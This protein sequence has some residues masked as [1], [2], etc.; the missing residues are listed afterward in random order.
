MTVSTIYEPVVYEGNGS[1]TSFP[2]TFNYLGVVNNVK[3]SIRN[4]E[5]G[6]LTV[7][8]YS[9]HYTI[10]GSN[11]V[12]NSGNKPQTGENVIIELYINLLQE[13]DY[14]ENGRLSAETLERDLD[15]L[16]LGTQ[17]LADSVDRTL[18]VG[19][20][21]DIDTLTPAEIIQ[22]VFDIGTPGASGQVL[23]TNTDGDLVWV[24][25]GESQWSG[26][27]IPTDGTA[28]QALVTDGSGNL[29]WTTISGGD[30]DFY[31]PEE[32]LV[33][34]KLT[35][36]TGTAFGEHSVSIQAPAATL[37]NLTFV[38]PNELGTNG[39]V[40]TTNG[41]GDLNWAESSMIKAACTVVSGSIV[42]SFNVDS[43]SEVIP[44]YI[45][46][47]YENSISNPIPLASVLNASGVASYTVSVMDNA[48]TSCS[49][50]T[51]LYQGGETPWVASN[52]DFSLIVLG[53]T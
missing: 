44:G 29:S 19:P 27:D 17:M 40:L 35:L 5:T 30:I 38:L 43:I 52:I 25:N 13:S 22:D 9:T 11:V 37:E 49:V 10:S 39:Q 46:V 42:S 50:Y 8:A 18:R 15:K 47:T 32:L 36:N 3:V 48:T 23:S 16:T 14:V 7:K 12:F 21:I 41:S 1:T 51:K 33:G 6:V 31:T 45:T 28:G 24:D 53:Y 2:I 4:V 20:D 34:A 26:Y